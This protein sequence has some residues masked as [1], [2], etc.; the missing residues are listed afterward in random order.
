MHSLVKYKMDARI[1]DN[2]VIPPT[3]LL[4]SLS[5]SRAQETES[6]GGLLRRR[7]RG[8]ERQKGCQGLEQSGT[9][10]FKRWWAALQPLPLG[11]N[12]E[13]SCPDQSM[14]FSENLPLVQP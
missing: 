13:L 5:Q 8:R 12:P 1:L 14:R 7:D 10:M 6:P 11:P 2:T 9:V 3:P 4:E